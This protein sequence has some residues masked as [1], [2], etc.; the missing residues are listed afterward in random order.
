MS[1]AIFYVLT[2][3]QVVKRAWIYGLY[4]LV[5]YTEG[6]PGAPST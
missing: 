3:G 6:G 1:T 2:D 4:S 5:E